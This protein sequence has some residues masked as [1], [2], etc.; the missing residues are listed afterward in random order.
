MT[1]FGDVLAA[2]QIYAE[3]TG[4][5]VDIAIQDMDFRSTAVK[6]GNGREP[7]SA[8]VLEMPPAPA[9]A[10]APALTRPIGSVPIQAPLP[11]EFTPFDHRR[12]IQAV[13]DAR[14]GVEYSAGDLCFEL[15]MNMPPGH[16]KRPAKLMAKAGW[17]Y[18]GY[19]SL[20]TNRGQVYRKPLP[21]EA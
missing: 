16:S 1:A 21:H 5:D 2:A 3:I 15:R 13:R 7:L 11:L 18:T 12:F 4:C 9:P 17:V 6:A 10:P 8:F 19:R 14:P 20:T